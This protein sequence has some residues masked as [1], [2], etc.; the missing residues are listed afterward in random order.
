LV[1]DFILLAYFM[2]LRQGRNMTASCPLHLI[3]PL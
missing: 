1:K 2:T 3:M